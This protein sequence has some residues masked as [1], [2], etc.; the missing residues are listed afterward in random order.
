MKL[1]F[2]LFLILLSSCEQKGKSHSINPSEPLT[3]YNQE[4]YYDLWEKNKH[5]KVK[6]I[7]TSCTNER[8]RAESDIKSGKLYYFYS[9]VWYEWKEMAE[10]LAEYH[11]EYKDYDHNCFGPPPGFEND[12]YEKLM[13]AEIDK[14]IGE[15][16][17]DSLWKIAERNF[18][19]KYPDS[20]Y[21]K[22]G[23]DIREK[24][25]AK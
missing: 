5:L 8:K 16:T 9:K 14:K 21:I 13:W 3:V 12:C 2:I 10:L 1:N 25:L 20:L 11:I 6:V 18:V 7:D 23:M 22:D 4:T 24:Y 17:I 15:N 19:L